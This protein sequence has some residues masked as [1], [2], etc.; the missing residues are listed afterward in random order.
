MRI[1]LVLDAL[2][3]AL[4]TR[5]RDGRADLSGL[6]CHNDAGSQFTS[7]RFTERLD[8]IGARPSIGTVADCPLTGQSQRTCRSVTR[9]GLRRCLPGG[10]GGDT[11]VR[12][13]HGGLP[14]AA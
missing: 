10:D 2:E 12:H 3:Q 4:W 8:E 1:A 6:I 11:P 7:V 14:A 9:R 13:E 5:R